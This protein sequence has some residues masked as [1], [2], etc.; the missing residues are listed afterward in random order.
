MIKVSSSLCSY[1]LVTQSVWLTA[2]P[3]TVAHQV[4][5]S[6]GFSGKNSGVGCHFCLWGK[7]PAQ[8]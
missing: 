2:A 4:P 8:G 3:C 5:L 6:M 1:C 7:F